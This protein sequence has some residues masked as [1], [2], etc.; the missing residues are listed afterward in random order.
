MLLF[1]PMEEGPKA[2]S[3]A[4][5]TFIEQAKNQELPRRLDATSFEIKNDPASA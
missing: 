2:P 4:L 5:V 1:R 3:L